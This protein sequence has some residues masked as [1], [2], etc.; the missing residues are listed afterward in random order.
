[1]TTWISQGNKFYLGVKACSY[2][3]KPTPGFVMAH[4]NIGGC[5]FEKIDHNKTK[6]INITDMDPKGNIP[7]FVKNFITEKRLKSSNNLE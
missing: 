3:I 7:D 5:I 1:M 4:M 2:P 6:V